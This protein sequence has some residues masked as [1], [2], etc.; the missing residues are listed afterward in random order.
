MSSRRRG[1]TNRSAKKQHK[2]S[3]TEANNVRSIM[4]LLEKNSSQAFNVKQLGRKLGVK[5]KK[6]QQHF[7]KFRLQLK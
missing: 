2:N 5:G 7:H 4:N 3:F 6:N 1:N